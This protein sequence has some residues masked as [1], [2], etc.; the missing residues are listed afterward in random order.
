MLG[1]CCCCCYWFKHSFIQKKTQKKTHKTY[2]YG[3]HN[4]LTA[5]ASPTVIVVNSTRIGNCIDGRILRLI[6]CWGFV[7]V[8]VAIVY[9][10]IVGNFMAGRFL[11]LF[12]GVL[13]LLLLLLLLKDGLRGT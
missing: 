11:C 10:T 3:P 8:V 5:Y 2:I 13:V 1:F 9:S 7:V 4:K 12:V 6:G